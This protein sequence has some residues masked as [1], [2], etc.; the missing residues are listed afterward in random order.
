MYSQGITVNLF[1]RARLGWH[2]S[3]ITLLLLSSIFLSACGSAPEKNQQASISP[4][5]YVDSTLYFAERTASVSMRATFNRE[6]PS[7]MAEGYLFQ[8]RTISNK[9][10]FLNS[11]SI[12]AGGKRLFLEEGQ[13]VLPN[14]KGVTLQ[15]SLE[16]SLFV[17]QYPSALVQ[18]RHNNDSQIFSIEL[19]QLTEF[20]PQ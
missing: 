5:T 8:F 3:S 4:Y 18:F 1:N 7:G 6:Q 9:P 17:A 12:V 13:I 19:H 10:A 14:Q 11:I 20:T 16:D 15:L 2:Q